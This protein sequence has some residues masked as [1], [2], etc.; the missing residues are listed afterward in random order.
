MACE[1]PCDLGC[2]MRELYLL[3]GMVGTLW[4]AVLD[5]T[6]SEMSETRAQ[7]ANRQI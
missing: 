5:V 3:S 7:R 2:V 4:L 6:S 1:A